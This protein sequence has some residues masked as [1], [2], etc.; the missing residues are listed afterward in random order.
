MGSLG[1]SFHFLFVEL[2]VEVKSAIYQGDSPLTLHQAQA[3]SQFLRQLFK[4]PNETQIFNKHKTSAITYLSPFGKS[5]TS[6]SW[7]SYTER[8]DID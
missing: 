6:F 3:V 4:E 5:E 2:E 8:L 7:K 1:D